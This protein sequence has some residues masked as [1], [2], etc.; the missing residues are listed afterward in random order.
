VVVVVVVE[1]LGVVEVVVVVV[2]VEGL[3]VV[4]VV[5][6]EV[7]VVEVVVV[8]VVVVEVGV[9]EVG[10]V[11]VGVVEV[12]V[13]VVG[14]V[15]V[16]GS[17]FAVQT[18]PSAICTIFLSPPMDHLSE[19]SAPICPMA[20]AKKLSVETPV[21]AFNAVEEVKTG[22]PSVAV[23]GENMSADA[24]DKVA[25]PALFHA[26]TEHAVVVEVGPQLPEAATESNPVI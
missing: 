16:G 21:T 18:V 23:A 25:T 1:G 13:V 6:V 5:V 3:G 12:G 11:E 26:Y 7:V 8:E 15:V 20:P 9:V 22:P 10:V 14:V 17:V 4:E 24:H 2:V 19:Q